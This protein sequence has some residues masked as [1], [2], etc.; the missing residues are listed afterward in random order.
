MI[1]PTERSKQ[2]DEQKQRLQ[3]IFG[4]LLHRYIL[5]KKSHF[6]INIYYIS[7]VYFNIQK[8]QHKRYRYRPI[9]I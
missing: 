4:L 3:D 5:K 1:L 7:Y 2:T 8:L 9:I 6:H